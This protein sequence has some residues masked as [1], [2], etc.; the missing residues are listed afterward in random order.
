MST[1]GKAGVAPVITPAV[2]PAV[3]TVKES[4]L[5]AEAE[6]RGYRHGHTLGYAAGLQ[7]AKAETT[8]MR[9]AMESEHDA[10]LVE[11]RARVD[12]EIA[13][14]AAAAAALAA[15][16]K[17]VLAEAEQT[18]MSCALALAEAVVGKELD[19]GET[20]SRAV[21]A[22]VLA[23]QDDADPPVLRV[24]PRDLAALSADARTAGVPDII[25]DPHLARGDA[26]AEYPDGFLD[27]RISTALERARRA[28][29]EPRA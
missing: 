25:A 8:L 9:E 12:A 4:E 28:L 19:D 5:H 7:D 26:V 11:L 29:L 23:R 10:L 24:H 1:N 27:A 18:L 21:L 16:T 2:Y 22:R 15:R 20:S 6:A 14:L 3:A 17:P 13:V